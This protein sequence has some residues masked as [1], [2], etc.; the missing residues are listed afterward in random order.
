MP[1]YPSQEVRRGATPPDVS[2]CLALRVIAA[3]VEQLEHS[4]AEHKPAP[5]LQGSPVQP[6]A[7]HML[8]PDPSGRHLHRRWLR[9]Q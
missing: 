4:I 2:I 9:R 6:I 5:S 1:R 3:A 7:A 8:Q